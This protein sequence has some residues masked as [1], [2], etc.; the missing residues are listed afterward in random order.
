[1]LNCQTSAR[2]FL[3]AGLLLVMGLAA[4]CD[5]LN[6]VLISEPTASQPTASGQATQTVPPTVVPAQPTPT[7]TPDIVR[8]TLW[9]TEALGPLGQ[10]PGAR[11]LS[12]QIAAFETA[13]LGVKVDVV[14]KKP[15]GKGG[16]LDFLTTT[17][18]AVPTALPD[19]AILDIRELAIAAKRELIQPLDGRI[20]PEVAQDLVAPARTAG[21]VGNAWF[22]LPFE[23]DVQHLIYNTELVATAPVTWTDVLSGTSQYLFPAGGQAT[24]AGE[25]GLVNDAFIIQYFGVGARLTSESGQPA[26]DKDA[27]TAVLQFYADGLAAGVIPNNA[28]QYASVDDTWPVYLAE[29][30]GLANTSTHQYLVARESFRKSSFAPIPT[31]ASSVT[32]VFRGWAYVLVARQPERQKVAW[33]LI[34]W[35][36]SPERLGEWALAADYL[37]TRLSALPQDSEDKYLQYLAELLQNSQVRPTG[38]GHDEVGRALQR[39]VQAVFAGTATPAE[40]AAQAA[41]SVP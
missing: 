24:V 30:V 26:L 5:R 36:T 2:Q 27:V 40:A 22:G 16:M 28:V 33:S 20:T 7:P 6:Q 32:S 9:I 3:I 38:P 25:G 18:A 34:E 14:L 29:E 23:A 31:R 19:V 13:N 17:A 4:G 1:M 35:L 8:L 12:A 39:A 21:Q 37:P 10:A 41:A 11:T 15:Y